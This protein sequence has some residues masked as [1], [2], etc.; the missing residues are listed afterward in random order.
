MKIKNSTNRNCFKQSNKMREV[1]INT[2]I[3]IIYFK[4]KKGTISNKT[5][6][7][8]DKTGEVNV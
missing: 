4:N 6:E 5:G 3:L 1:G 2:N 7:S 8:K